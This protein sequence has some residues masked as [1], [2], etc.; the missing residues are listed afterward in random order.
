MSYTDRYEAAAH[1]VAKAAA[2]NAEARRALGVAP[3]HALLAPLEFHEEVRRVAALMDEDEIPLVDPC[4]TDG[5]TEAG[6]TPTGYCA[7]HEPF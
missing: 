2:V 6:V 1:A 5:C 3:W 4:K 7:G